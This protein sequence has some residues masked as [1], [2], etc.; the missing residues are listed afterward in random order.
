MYFAAS[1]LTASLAIGLTQA[2][3][4]EFPWD[5][6]RGKPYGPP[7]KPIRQVEL[8]PRP[9]YLVNDMDEGELKNKLL[10]CSEMDFKPTKF[11]IGH[12]GGGTLQFPEETKESIMAGTRM[13]AGIQECDV[14]FTKDRQLIC[15][16][17]QCDL[18]TTTNIVAI[19]E[20]NAKCTQPF[21]PAAKGKDATANCCTSD[22]TLAEYKSLC[23]K[24]D[25]FNASATTPKDFLHGTPTFRTDLYSTCGTVLSLKDYI[26]MVDAYGLLFTPELKTPLV[27]MPFQGDYTQEKY[28]QQMVDTFRQAGIKFDRIFAQSFLLDDILYWNKAEPDFAKQAMYLDENGDTPETFAQAVANLTTYAKQGVKTMAP[29]LYY[30]VELDKN[31]KIVPSSYATTCKKL[32]LKIIT[33]TLERSGLLSGSDHGGYYYTSIANVTNND[34]DVYNLLDVLAR[35]VGVLGV[36]SDWSATVTYYANC[37]GLF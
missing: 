34:G 30:L 27:K 14:T 25:G 8:G 5:G 16:H 22:I 11:S 4:T 2:I 26:Q 33:W 17:S 21:Q 29:P 13:G 15:R 3:P 37:F 35:D 20:L 32:G 1:V 7:Q 28:A 10:S 18:H 36:F 24:M 12:R 23:G 9:Y 31:N 19:P 6:W